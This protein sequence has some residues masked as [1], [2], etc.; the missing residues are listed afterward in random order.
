MTIKFDEIVE[1]ANTEY[2]NTEIDLGEGDVVVLR[3][4][5]Q[6]SEDERA[7]LRAAREERKDDEDDQSLFE[8]LSDS[9]RAVAEDKEA[10][11]RLLARCTNLALLVT[12]FKKYNG[13]T[14]A[15]EA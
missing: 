8:V 12:V 15:G 2:A 5:L 14:Q 13:D 3:N 6:L 7:A 4:A 10:A 9:I 1:A 11:E